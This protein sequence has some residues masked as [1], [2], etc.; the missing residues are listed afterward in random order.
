MGGGGGG[1]ERDIAGGFFNV[2]N[3]SKV[4]LNP[5]FCLL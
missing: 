5:G 2:L 4:F 1:E 3:V